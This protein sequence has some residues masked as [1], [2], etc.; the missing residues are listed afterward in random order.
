M[1]A[2]TH[3]VVESSAALPLVTFA[4]SSFSGAATDPPGHE[5]LARLATKLMRRTGGGL[6]ALEL[7]ARIDRL[8]AAL[9][10]EVSP[11]TTTLSGTVLSR[12]LDALVDLVIDVVARPG[13]AEAELDRIRRETIA[14]L[15]EARDD[16]RGLVRRWF[17]RKVFEGHPYGRP[18]AG[19]PAT[20]A[21][22]DRA[23]ARA[24]LERTFASSNLAFAFA[25]DL[26]EA[27]AQEIANRIAT[28]LRLGPR[29]ADDVT[30]PTARPGRRLILVDKPERTQ[31]QILIGGLGTHPHD[32]DHVALHVANTIFGGTFSARLTREVRSKR[33][34]SYGAYSGLPIDRHRQAFTMWTFPKASDAAACIRLELELLEAW[35]RDG[36][37]PE[38]LAQAKSYL[39]RSHAFS[40]DTAGKRAS[41]QLDEIVYD[42]PAGYHSRYL[43]EVR[44]VTLAACN[45]AVH[46]R[47]P[48]RDLVVTVVAT[49]SELQSELQAAIPGLEHTEIIPFDSD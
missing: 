12:S 46:A 49:A 29:L 1:S 39:V 22:L 32:P 4:I 25:G 42:L 38:E 10:A 48:E 20:L 40:V 15:V 9:S 31:T 8:G 44:A 36:I 23:S 45:E 24:H 3:V 34:W 37:T 21:R 41:H 33:G 26:S 18:T 5:G 19:T 35:R 14:E 43:D 17:R 16:D 47:I 6:D 27:R 7:D 2:P 28:A 11:S 30:E 13:L